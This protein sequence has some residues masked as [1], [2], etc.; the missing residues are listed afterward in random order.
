T[1]Q[2]LRHFLALSVRYDGI[3]ASVDQHDGYR[4][5]FYVVDRR[6]RPQTLIMRASDAEKAIP[7]VGEFVVARH[8]LIVGPA[9]H[10]RGV[11]DSRYRHGAAIDTALQG[12]AGQSRIAA[13]AG[14]HDADS[15]RIGDPAADE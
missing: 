2:G 4:N 1:L 9:E 8:H 11:R 15:L 5:R 7:V 13:V 6:N 10:T 14:A 3:V 12:Y